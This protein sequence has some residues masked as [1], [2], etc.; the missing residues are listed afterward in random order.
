VSGTSGTRPTV[1]TEPGSRSLGELITSLDLTDTQK[2]MLGSRFLNQVEWMA[3]RAKRA[4]RRYV[5]V[6]LPAVAGSILIPP[7]VTLT[8]NSSGNDDRL[9]WITFIVSLTVAFLTA[10]E[11]FFHF[12]NSWRHY[13]RTAETLKSTGWR[14][15][16][17]TGPFR[18]FSTHASAYPSFT[19]RVE[20]I[21]DEDVDQYLG[22][23]AVEQRSDLKRDVIV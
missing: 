4:R 9:K 14:F 23:I 17:L 19:E 7:L 20:D 22:R 15:M 5:W 1:L 11:E 13:R 3:G 8:I 2:E 10:I 18:H 12:G 21:L 6:R 16:F